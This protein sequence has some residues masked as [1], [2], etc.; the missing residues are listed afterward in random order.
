MKATREGL[1]DFLALRR[2]TVAL[3]LVVILV[4]SGER[5]ADKFMPLYLTTL[6]GGAMAVGLYGALRNL[7]G[8]LYSL[9]AGLLAD[10]LGAGRSLALFSVMAAA[11][12]AVAGLASDWGLVLAA[13][14][15]FIAWSAVS[16]PAMLGTIA[17]V[18]PENR[19]T[20]G[21]T[22]HSLIRRIPMAL[23]PL[24]G[25]YLI[26]A[27][28]SERGCSVGFF[29]AAAMAVVALGVQRVLMHEPAGEARPAALPRHPIILL[30]R[31]SPPLRNLLTADI[32]MR[33]CEQIPE[34][35]VVLWCLE[36]LGTAEGAAQFGWLVTIE[37]ITAVLIYIPV[38]RLADQSAK[39]PFVVATFVFFSLFPLALGFC[40]SFPLLVAA[41]VLKGLKEFGEPTRKA[42][43]LDLSPPEI[44]ASMFGLYYL[45]RDSVVSLFALGGWLLWE[46]SPRAN[47]L[48]AFVFGAAGTAWFW[49]RGRD[50]ETAGTAAA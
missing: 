8:A 37:M 1:A 50:H 9:P 33:G 27:M 46:I 22:L 45:I 38:A 36:K 5:M 12:F 17:K 16:A 30:R 28:G 21:V 6:G 7:L 2:P 47:F 10:H 31:M 19:R 25:G 3:L 26:V 48:T 43:I 24:A 39:K 14:P 35:F 15:L 13:A 41:F 20:M 44:R 29:A 18:L 40:D 11:G 32:L 34:A 4:G 42:L 49:W 23:G